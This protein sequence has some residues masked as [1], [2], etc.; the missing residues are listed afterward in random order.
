MNIKVSLNPT[1]PDS[2][3]GSF[4]HM[5]DPFSCYDEL[6]CNCM[7]LLFFLSLSFCTLTFLDCSLVCRKSLEVIA[8]ST[9]SEVFFCFRC[10]KSGI[11]IA[12][13]LPNSNSQSNHK[14]TKLTLIFSAH[15]D[16]V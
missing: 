8:P 16:V 9:E 2:F 3:P 14:S 13:V 11:L 12:Y 15:S 1:I 4:A 10:D 7:Q 5:C 6:H